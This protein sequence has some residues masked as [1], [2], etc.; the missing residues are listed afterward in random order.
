MS[1]YLV[2]GTAGD[3]QILAFACDTAELVETARL[4]HGTHPV[5]TAALGRALSAAAMMA[6]QLKNDE[7]TITL[8]FEGNGPLER[9]VALCDGAGRLRGYVENP[10]VD[11]PLNEK[12]KLDVAGAVGVGV[13]TITKDLGLKEPYTGSSHLVTSEIAEDL[14][15]YFTVSE[16][17][18][19]AVSLGVMVNKDESVWSAG[20]FILQLLPGA[21]EET[22]DLLQERV[23]AFPPVS[24]FLAM[25]KKPEEILENLLGD[26]DFVPMGRKELAFRCNCS[27]E[28]VARALLSIGADELDKLIAEDEPVEMGCHYCGEKYVFTVDEIREM[29][30][31]AL[32]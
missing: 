29:K 16:Q 23:V 8:R 4:R 17:I 5:A 24:Q 6:A 3:G 18:P 32:K 22:A 26:L 30:E 14:A 7:E 21:S 1:D 11:L 27:R 25:G 9:T 20:G 19:S 12:G 31:Q 2:H 13:L 10:A 28:K 15:Y